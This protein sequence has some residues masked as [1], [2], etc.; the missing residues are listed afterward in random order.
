M[1]KTSPTQKLF[2]IV[3]NL[4]EATSSSAGPVPALPTV[5]SPTA[6]LRAALIDGAT[7]FLAADTGEWE[8]AFD[9]LLD[10]P[11]LRQRMGEAAHAALLKRMGWPVWSGL[12]ED[13]YAAVLRE[14]VRAPRNLDQ[15][16]SR[17]SISS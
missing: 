4:A 14:H 8:R 13:V 7:G 3:V 17:D 2:F 5:A 16:P 11:S 9:R 1:G 10:D 12:A 15:T 6:P